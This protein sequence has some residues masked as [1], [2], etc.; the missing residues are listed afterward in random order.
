MSGF[1]AG[2]LTTPSSCPFP[3]CR[4]TSVSGFTLV[5]D[6]RFGGRFDVLFDVFFNVC[7]DT[8]MP[9]AHLIPHTNAVNVTHKQQITSE[10]IYIYR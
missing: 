9:G 1:H 2:Y 6:G 8:P 10:R 7:F 5:Y 3:P 4:G